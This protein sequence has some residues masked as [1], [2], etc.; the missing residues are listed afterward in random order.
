[1]RYFEIYIDWLFWKE[2]KDELVSEMELTIENF[3]FQFG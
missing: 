1:M 2:K 3:E